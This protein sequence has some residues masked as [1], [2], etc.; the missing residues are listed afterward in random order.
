MNRGPGVF[1]QITHNKHPWLARQLYR[2]FKFWNISYFRRYSIKLHM[3]LSLIHSPTL[4][5]TKVNQWI[6]MS[7]F[8]DYFFRIHHSVFDFSL[9]Y[10]VYNAILWIKCI[11]IYGILWSRCHVSRKVIFL[12]YVLRRLSFIWIRKPKLRLS[13]ETFGW[14]FIMGKNDVPQ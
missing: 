14:V 3:M 13:S 11:K 4:L 7:G 10:F 12:A 9:N 5:H 2:E 8:G 1:R 6:S